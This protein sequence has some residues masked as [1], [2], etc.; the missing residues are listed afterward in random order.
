[1]A[2]SSW[3]KIPES[4]AAVIGVIFIRTDTTIPD[5]F[6]RSASLG[7]V[8]RIQKHYSKIEKRVR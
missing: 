1:M 5:W 3:S 2:E 4:M 8:D 7:L 6:E